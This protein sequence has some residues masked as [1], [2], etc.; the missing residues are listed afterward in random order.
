[1]ETNQKK[2]H[3]IRSSMASTVLTSGVLPTLSISSAVW[4]TPGLM[5]TTKTIPAEEEEPREE[6]TLQAEALVPLANV[7]HP[8]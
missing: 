3:L 1:M 8:V 4:G 6:L 5:V 2:S 7:M